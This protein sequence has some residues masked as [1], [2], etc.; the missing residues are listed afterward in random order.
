[1]IDDY[2][3]SLCVFTD[4]HEGSVEVLQMAVTSGSVSYLRSEP[5]SSSVPC[6]SLDLWNNEF[7]RSIC[8]D[9]ANTNSTDSFAQRWSLKEFRSV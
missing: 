7:I 8:D 4:K 3:R 9:G 5:N 1:M 2:Y 6:V